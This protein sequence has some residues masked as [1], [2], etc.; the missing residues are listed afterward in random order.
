MYPSKITSGINENYADIIAG[1]IPAIKFV[2]GLLL[3]NAFVDRTENVGIVPTT[4]A[5]LPRAVN[6]LFIRH[7]P[8][9]VDFPG[10]LILPTT[11]D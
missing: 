5:L 7:W 9:L 6:A 2:I 10:L 3:K 1:G 8:S 11:I 4:L